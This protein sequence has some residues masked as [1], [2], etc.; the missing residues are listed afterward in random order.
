[1]RSR[2]GVG[3]LV[4][5]QRLAGLTA[6]GKQRVR[7]VAPREV[8]DRALLVG[9]VGDQRRVEIDVRSVL[10][11]RAASTRVRGRPLA[12]RAALEPRGV[13]GDPVDHPKRC[14]RRHDLHEQDAR[15]ARRSPPS[16][17]VTARSRT[18]TPRSW[19]ER[20]A[21]RSASRSDSARVRARLVGDVGQQRAIGVRDQP[22]SVRR[23]LYRET[24]PIV[25]PLPG[26]PPE[27]AFVL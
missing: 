19:P 22:G 4:T 8:A 10:A 18:T 21:L 7:A 20:R 5:R 23:D 1:M 12:R 3:G 16:A 13:A 17:S 14:R 6:I 15:S 27:L 2:A 24:T 11:R 9:V 26:D 25:R